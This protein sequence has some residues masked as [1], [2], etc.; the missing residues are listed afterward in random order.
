MQAC[1]DTVILCGAVDEEMFTREQRFMDKQLQGFLD[2]VYEEQTEQ[3]RE[4]KDKV[5]M[6][7]AKRAYQKSTLLD[8]ITE[9][10]T[11]MLKPVNSTFRDSRLSSRSDMDEMVFTAKKANLAYNNEGINNMLWIDEDPVEDKRPQFSR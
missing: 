2:A 10:G 4:L 6:H 9:E 1:M 3:Q 7:Q 8:N 11:M 5:M